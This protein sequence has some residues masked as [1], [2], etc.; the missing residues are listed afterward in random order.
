MGE[1]YK[2]DIAILMTEGDYVNKMN[3]REY[4]KDAYLSYGGLGKDGLIVAVDEEN[5]KWAFAVFGRAEQIIPEAEI[6]KFFKAYEDEDTYVKGVRSYL[7]TVETYLEAMS[8]AE[9]PEASE[10]PETPLVV[11]QASGAAGLPLF[12]DQA[13]VLTESE[14]K[15]LLGLLEGVTNKHS[16]DTVVLVLDSLEGKEPMLYAADFFEQNGY[17]QGSELDG[18][19]LLVSV[20]DRDFAFATFGFGM[21]AFTTAGQEYLDKLFLPELKEDNYYGAFVAYTEAVDDFLTKAK[22]GKP[23]DQGNIPL[24]DSERDSYRGFAILGSLVIA[25]IIAFVVTRIWKGQL[26]SVRKEDLA[27]SYVREGSMSVEVESDTFLYSHVDQTEKP[28]ES[29]N[30]SSHSSSS[31]REYSGHSGKY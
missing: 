13:G 20:K 30:S 26:V 14:A 9:K 25:L 5:N 7:E 28:Q 23:Y 12:I 10:E 29:N 22:A 2:L 16:F 11:E 27:Q 4:A 15:G 6:D 19:I 31:G 1:Q 21:K 3:L 17:G 24:T 18:A 8:P